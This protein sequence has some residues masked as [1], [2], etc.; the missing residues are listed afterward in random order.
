MA[1]E[2]NI[3]V[4][5]KIDKESYDIDVA[6]PAGVPTPAAPYTFSIAESGEDGANLL[7]VVVGDSTHFY[8]AVSPPEQV[9]EWTGDVVQ[10]LKVVVNDGG[11]V[12]EDGKFTDNKNP[13]PKP[14]E[15]K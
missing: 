6:I 3:K 13:D 9:K 11:Y 15:K 10:D 1:L 4:G 14:D 2:A 12:P 5:L 8:V 7:N